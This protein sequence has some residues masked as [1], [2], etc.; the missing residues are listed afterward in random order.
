MGGMLLLIAALASCKQS[1]PADEVADPILAHAAGTPISNLRFK[2]TYTDHL[3][4]TGRNDTPENRFRHLDNLI[5]LY[6]M[7]EEARQIGLD[8][9]TSFLAYM[10]FER[11]KALGG[12]FYERLFLDTLSFPTDEDTRE[13]FIKHNQRVVV[14]HLRYGTKEEAVEALVALENGAVFSDLANEAY[15]L[16]EYDSMAGSLGAVQYWQLDDVF[17]ETAFSIPVGSYSQPVRTRHGWHIIHVQDRL[18]QAM[19]TESEYQT[20][21]A[22]I[23]GKVWQRKIRIEGDAF[24]REY[25]EARNAQ[26][27]LSG[28]RLLQKAIQDRLDLSGYQDRMEAAPSPEFIEAVDEELVP[29]TVLLTYELDGE[30]LPFTAREYVY[31]L[32]ELPV[33]EAYHKTAASVGRALRNEVFARMGAAQG[34][35][36]DPIVQEELLYKAALFLA[37]GLREIT[38]AQFDRPVTENELREGFERMN[39][40]R[41]KAASA[42]YWAIPAATFQEASSIKEKIASGTSPQAYPSFEQFADYDFR[43]HGYLS[44]FVSTAPLKEPVVVGAGEDWFVLQVDRVAET[45]TT[46]EEVREVVEGRLTAQLPIFDLVQ[47][48]RKTMSVQLDTAQFVGVMRKDGLAVNLD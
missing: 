14:R 34:L 47:E 19:L 16:A 20:R 45:Y 22:G 30:T 25:M 39:L 6:L 9:D 27:N 43:D 13:A 32:K 7:G 38:R 42:D 4:Q 8:S 41:L 10:D 3:I 21:K 15:K 35:A 18:S 48:L 31:W 1:I 28:M 12:R 36:E 17:A 23:G 37:G 2:T 33:G 40:R 24:V 5:D 46:L 29:E 11:R 26:V 44:A